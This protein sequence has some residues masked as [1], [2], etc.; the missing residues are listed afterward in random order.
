MLLHYMI[1][2]QICE[3]EQI[4]QFNIEGYTYSEDLSSAQELVFIR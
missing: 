1:I 3:I 2:N 4:K